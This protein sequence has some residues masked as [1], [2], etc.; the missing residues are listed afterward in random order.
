MN[1]PKSIASVLAVT[2]MVVLWPS[3]VQAQAN[4]PSAPG[5]RNINP[6]ANDPVDP[7]TRQTPRQQLPSAVPGSGPE[8]IIGDKPPEGGWDGLAK[9]L[10]AI[11]P[12]FDTRIPLNPAEISQRI[13]GLIRT[14]RLKE[15]LDA[16]EKRQAVE[17]NRHTPGTDVQLMFLHARLLTELKRLPEAETIYQRMT[18]RF[19]ELP[20]PWNN[21]ADLYVKR[22]ELEQARRALEMSIMINPNSAR[23]QANLGDVQLVL[24]LRAYERA[25]KAGATDLRPRIRSVTELIESAQK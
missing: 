17:A 12:G 9:I 3:H 1:L 18:M 8:L 4:Y 2:C 25:V 16:I 5:T 15:A 21:L 13:E 22:D 7:N 23:T 11:A 24:A 19:P 6:L 20:E 10:D 14:G